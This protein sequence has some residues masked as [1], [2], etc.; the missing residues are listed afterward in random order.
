M[1]IYV[2]FSVFTDSQAVGNVHGFLELG[3]LPRQGE[4]VSFERPKEGVTPIQVK[5]FPYQLSVE[6]VI[7]TAGGGQGSLSLADVVLGSRDDAKTLF[8]YL[9][10]GFGL[11]ADEYDGKQ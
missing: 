8:A 7:H 6:Q 9:E 1:R 5:G 4:L 2:D 11:Y 10:Q 3:A